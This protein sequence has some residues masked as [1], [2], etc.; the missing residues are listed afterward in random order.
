MEICTCDERQIAKASTLAAGYSVAPAPTQAKRPPS[1]SEG[2]P[3]AAFG[4]FGAFQAPAATSVVGAANGGSQSLEAQVERRL[5]MANANAITRPSPE[6]AAM[7]E[8][9]RRLGERVRDLEK[10]LNSQ[11]EDEKRA[12]TAALADLERRL[13]GS[14]QALGAAAKVATTDWDGGGRVASVPGVRFSMKLDSRFAEIESRIQKTQE[15]VSKRLDDCTVRE[16]RES[17]KRA[18]HE[19]VAMVLHLIDL[20]VANLEEGAAL[21]M[22]EMRSPRSPGR[23]LFASR[24]QKAQSSAAAPAPTSELDASSSSFAYA[25]G[26]GA[27][28]SAGA[29]SA[30]QGEFSN[31]PTRQGGGGWLSGMFGGGGRGKAEAA[32]GTLTETKASD[33]SM[34]QQQQLSEAEAREAADALRLV[35]EAEAA[36][37]RAASTSYPAR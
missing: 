23:L 17:A 7:A 10:S 37:A 24:E 9:V 30:Q 34:V 12:R 31:E 19:E 5:Q 14:Y 1:R 4:A 6:Q 35:A 25:A 36:E 22:A 21:R 13:F 27:D 20:R 29:A 28:A 26:F 3:A 18:A 8:D 33:A 15:E 16:V 11:V 32:G 2:S